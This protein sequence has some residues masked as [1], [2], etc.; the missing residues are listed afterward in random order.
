MKLPGKRKTLTA[1]TD[2][3]TTGSGAKRKKEKITME[4]KETNQS[5]ELTPNS[6]EN[7]SGGKI[8]FRDI[9]DIPMTEEEKKQLKEL[10]RRVGES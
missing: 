9:R 10:E 5:G 3:K 6:L 7:I 8:R 2:A 4:N 1:Q